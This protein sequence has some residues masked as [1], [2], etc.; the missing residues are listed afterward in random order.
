MVAR[1]Q[2]EGRGAQR[3]SGERAERKRH[4]I[5]RAARACFVREGFGAGMDQIAAEAGVSKVTVYNHF[6]SKEALFLEVIT[7][8]LRGAL[9]KAVAGTV[10]LADAAESADLR[11]GLTET[12]REW[13]HGMT[14]PEVIALRRLVTAE[15]RQFPEL[16]AAWERHGP[17]DTYT[18]LSAA[19]RKLAAQGRLEMDDVDLAIIQFQGLALYPHLIYSTYG[20]TLSRQMT[21]DLIRTG[22]EMF[23]SYYRYRA[24]DDDTG[25]R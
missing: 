4:A 3:P 16:G 22:V 5:V 1:G 14:D 9:A 6:G 2:D 25:P 18:V 12:A 19:F 23:L 24:P 10:R 8:A 13:V 20:K 15:V 21:E 11:A 17:G 7:D